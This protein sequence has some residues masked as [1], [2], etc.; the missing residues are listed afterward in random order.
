MGQCYVDAARQPIV[1]VGPP[2]GGT[3]SKKKDKKRKKKK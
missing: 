2:K 1:D 3:V